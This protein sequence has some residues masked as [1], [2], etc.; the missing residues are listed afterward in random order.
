MVMKPDEKEGIRRKLA[1][2]CHKEG[3][4]H[5]YERKIDGALEWRMYHLQ[6]TKSQ[7]HKAGSSGGSSSFYLGCCMLLS[8]R[9]SDH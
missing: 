8:Q 3:L 7:K 9:P 5:G 2:L 6:K 1:N 4:F